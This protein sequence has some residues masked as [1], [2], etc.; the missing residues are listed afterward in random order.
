MTTTAYDLSAKLLTSDSRWSIEL[1]TTKIAYVDDAGFDKIEI[2][3]EHAF[4]FAGSSAGID[5]WKKYIHA[6]GGL[7]IPDLNGI[8]LF[9]LN[10]TTQEILVSYGQDIALPNIDALKA[11]FA[12]SGAR[13]AAKCWEKNGCGRQAIETAKSLDYY[14]GG[15]TKFLELATKTHNL[16]NNIDVTQLGKQFLAKGMIMYINGQSSQSVAT[17]AANDTEVKEL[18]EKIAQGSIALS[19]PCDAMMMEPT[20]EDNKKVRAAMQKIFGR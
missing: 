9:A 1:G 7:N 18:C 13:H 10:V 3:G 20:E 8:A 15:T 5:S 12:G 16:V 11:S 4:L 14:T 17:A 6:G 2:V 19:A